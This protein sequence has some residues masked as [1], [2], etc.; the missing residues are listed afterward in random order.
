MKLGI[1]S[2][3]FIGLFCVRLQAQTAMQVVIQVNDNEGKPLPGATIARQNSNTI[4]T[5]NDLGIFILKN[6]VINEVLTVSFQGFLDQKITIVKER[7][8]YKVTLDLDIKQL[9]DVI[10]VGYESKSKNDI[11]TSASRIDLKNSSEGGYSNF[12]QLIGGRAAGV[13]VMQ[14]SSDPGAGLSIEIRGIN[15]LTSSTQPLYVLDGMPLNEPNLDLSNGGAGLASTTVASPLTMINP[16]DIE[17]LVVLKDAA[18]T[19]IYGSRGSNGVVL[20]TT[21]SGKAGRVKISFSANYS[22]SRPSK[23]VKMLGAVDYANRAN[24][25]WNYRNLTGGS[26]TPQPYLPE[27]IPLLV[28]YDHQ[29]EFEQASPS[30]D[31]NL[32][33]SGGDENNKY[34]VS[35]QYF[36]LDGIIPGSDLKRYSGKFTYEGRIMPKLKLSVSANITNTVS[37]GQPTGT[38]ITKILGWGAASPLINPDGEP[39]YLSGYLYGRGEANFYSESLGNTVY[40]NPRFPQALVAANTGT[41]HPLDYGG[42]NGVKNA[43]TNTQILTNIGL[44]WTIN[45][46]LNLN[47]KFG[48]TSFDGLLENYTPRTYITNNSLKGA[49]SAGNS[50]N[51]SLLYQ[52]QLNY[53]KRFGNVHNFS[54]FL[55]ASAERFT[56]K[57]QSAGSQGFVSDLTSY[58][59]LQSGSGPGVPRSGFSGNQLASVVLSSSYN[60]KQKY[61]VN[62]TGR[63]DGTSKFAPGNQYAIFP[64][65]STSWRMNQEKWFAPLSS[66]FSEVRWRA[67][68]G[69]V[70]NQKIAPYS[71]LSTLGVASVVMGNTINVGYAPTGLPNPNL[72]W[73]RSNSF[74]LGSDISI[75]KGRVSLTTEVYRKKTDKLLFTTTPPLS[76]GYKSI[77]QNIASLTNQGL[78]LT[79]DAK[80]INNEKFKWSLNA[81]IAFNKD[82]VDR[83]SGGNNEYLNVGLV[84]GSAYLFRIE[85][86][87]SLGQF[88]GLKTIGVWTDETIQQ[89][90]VLFQPGAKEGWRRYADLNGDGLLN[91]D[92]RTY[93]GSASP[94][95]FGGFSSTLTY[96]NF[97]LSAFFSYS[98][99]NQIFNNYEINNVSMYSGYGN[100]RKEIY[101]K[102]YRFITADMSAEEAEMIRRNNNSTK[103]Q[104]SGSSLDPRE[105]TD[106]YLEDGTYLRCRDITLSWTLPS[107]ILKRLNFSSVKLYLNV[108]NAFTITPYS[109]YNP[110]VNTGSGLIRGLDGGTAPVNRTIRLGLN[111]N[112]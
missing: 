2:L 48:M 6:A 10:I 11:A 24:E 55:V 100:V 59:S 65:L 35:G 52:M 54:A 22:Q 53:N 44:T 105:S 25:I 110:E 21:K 36:L 101:D 112:F 62:A 93:Y 26:T 46:E 17:S 38:L 57:M 16:N 83:L 92:D 49:A 27:E 31:L 81:N 19:A 84:G 104:A 76:T 58:Y 85:P 9:N 64:A 43:S 20:I 60:Y 97:E 75:L 82:R 41:N 106:Y 39:N 66:F 68:W 89:K 18:A 111:V 98:V 99:G 74:N 87:K 78:E 71:T 107:N 79:L 61:Y 50:Q 33:L 7:I 90:P 102:R 91:D 34:Y 73:E 45:K 40:Y 37:N 12:Q 8:T 3:I 72:Q 69:I 80:V 30:T 95:Y 28:S 14:N 88:Y 67:S 1:L 63:L 77:I 103:V 86:G 51:I 15:S 96:H 13:N 70:G 23:R 4:A 47:G 5:T 56:S 108:Q 109:G 32:S 94:K 29:K 42:P